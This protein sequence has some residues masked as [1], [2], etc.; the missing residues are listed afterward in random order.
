MDTQKEDKI[1]KDPFKITIFLSSSSNV[2]PVYRQ[3]VKEIAQKLASKG[4]VI[5][6]GGTNIGL[7]GLLSK[8]FREAGGR[9]IGVIPKSLVAYNLHDEDADQLIICDSIVERKLKMIDLANAILVLPGGFGTIEE[10]L[11][12]LVEIQIQ[13][14]KKPLVILNINHYFDMLINFFEKIVKEGF[15]HHRFLQLFKVV[16]KIDEAISYIEGYTPPRFEKGWFLIGKQ[17]E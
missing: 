12:T 2:D 4:Y 5:V 14:L 9:I 8:T 6:Y 13:G 11:T 10:L 15:A 7:M 1:G 3:S 16:N 17:K